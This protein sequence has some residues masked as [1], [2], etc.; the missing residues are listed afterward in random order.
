MSIRFLVLWLIFQHCFMKVKDSSILRNDIERLA[1]NFLSF[2][3]QG[4]IF[5]YLS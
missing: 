3:T 5:I 2:R 1:V 4:E